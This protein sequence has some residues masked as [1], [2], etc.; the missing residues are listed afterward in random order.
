MVKAREIHP[1]QLDSDLSLENWAERFARQ[2]HLE[3]GAK[4][5]QAI[6]LIEELELK[7]EAA[8]DWRGPDAHRFGLEMADIL[9]TMPIDEDALIA[10]LLYRSVRIGRLQLRDVREAFGKTVAKLIEGVQQMAI[11]S[12]TRQDA[13]QQ[14]LGAAEHQADAVRRMLV[15]VIDDVRVALIKLAERTAAI[16]AVKSSDKA[17]RLK[18]ARE[19]SEVYAPLARR[20]GIGHLKWELEAL[21][22]RYL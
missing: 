4:L 5:S 9:S 3:T 19:V 17:R 8:K 11:I 21:P 15:A 6:Q 2:A 14:F 18:V 7:D 16:R 12:Q 20:L 1:I 13:P 10:A 22:F